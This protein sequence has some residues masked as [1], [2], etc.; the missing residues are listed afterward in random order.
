MKINIITVGHPHLSFAKQGI[1]EYQKRIS[2]FAN[3]SLIHIKENKGMIKKILDTIGNDFC[4]LLDEGGKQYTSRDL[5]IFLEKQK[6]QSRNITI[7]V[8]GPDGH[9]EELRNRADHIWSLSKLTFPHDIAT[10]IVLETLYRSLTISA[11]HPYH[12][13]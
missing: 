6:N 5:S 4:I 1:V 8:G 3:I 11:G 9:E 13:D 12:R 7:V 2:R 10:M